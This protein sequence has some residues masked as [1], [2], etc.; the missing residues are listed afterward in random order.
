MYDLIYDFILN[1][2][3]AT[4]MTGQAIPELAQILSHVTIFLLYYVMVQLVLW[5]FRIFSGIL[6]F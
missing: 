4:S 3:L 6:R 2:F 1:D 5:F